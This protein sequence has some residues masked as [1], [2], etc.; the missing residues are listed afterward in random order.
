MNTCYL[1]SPLKTSSQKI[2]KKTSNLKLN[3]ITYTLVL[4]VLKNLLFTRE[5]STFHTYDLFKESCCAEKTSITTVCPFCSPSNQNI[6]L[7]RFLLLV[8]IHNLT[9]IVGEI[10]LNISTKRSKPVPEQERKAIRKSSQQYD[11]QQVSNMIK[12]K[13]DEE[14]MQQTEEFDSSV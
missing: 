10:Y 8:E 5:R 6:P 3:N 4:Y 12:Q 11:I 1:L 2:N 13:D 9:T 14:Q 7:G